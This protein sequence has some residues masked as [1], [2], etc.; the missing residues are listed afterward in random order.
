MKLLCVIGRAI[1]SEYSGGKTG[2][3]GTESCTYR[4]CFH[5]TRL[6]SGVT[7]E[8]STVLSAKLVFNMLNELT[9]TILAF[10]SHSFQHSQRS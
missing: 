10:V 7:R 3:N 2:I 8:T 6:I 5:H 4:P 1:F 9:E